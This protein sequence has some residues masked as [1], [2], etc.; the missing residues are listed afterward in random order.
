VV[1]ILWVK[2]TAAFVLPEVKNDEL[3]NLGVE[4]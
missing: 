1:L 2:T 4:L 3:W